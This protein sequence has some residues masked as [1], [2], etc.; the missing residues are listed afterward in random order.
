MTEQ[1]LPPVAVS[2]GDPSGIGIEVTVGAWQALD[3]AVPFFLIADPA[4]LAEE[5]PIVIIDSPDQTAKALP[6]GV[7]VLLH[8]F[9]QEAP[10]GRPKPDNAR[11]VVEVIERGVKLVQEGK[12]SALCTA[13][14]AKK[15]LVDHAGFTCPGHTEF[16]AELTGADRPVMMIASEDLR[17]V[18]AT[19]HIPLADVPT[20]LTESRRLS[21]SLIPGTS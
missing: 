4:H 21:F 11:G 16:L 3:G 13:P 18:P 1:H 9:P 2:C 20:A 5:V 17:V 19:I 8:A 14:I 6:R 10:P 15:E 7:P 12:A